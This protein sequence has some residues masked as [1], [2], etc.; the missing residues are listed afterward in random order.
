[1]KTA[2]RKYN[3]FEYAIQR[4]FYHLFLHTAILGLLGAVYF[5]AWHQL[6]TVIIAGGMAATL[7]NELKK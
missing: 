6:A 5:G 4:G 3:R 1:M 2:T 7:K